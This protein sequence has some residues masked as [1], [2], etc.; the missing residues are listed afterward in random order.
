MLPPVVE[1][2]AGDAIPHSDTAIIGTAAPSGTTDPSPRFK[3]G[4]H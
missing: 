3:A 1:V 4:H 2:L